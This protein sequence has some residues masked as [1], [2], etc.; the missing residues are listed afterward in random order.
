MK[1][2]FTVSIIIPSFNRKK[3][4]EQAIQSVLQ[5]AH[6][7]LHMLKCIVVDDGSNDGSYEQLSAYHDRGEIHLITHP[8]YENKGQS[9][10]INLGLRHASG[11]FI[12]ILDSDDYFA[13]QKITEQLDFLIKHPDIGMVYGKGVAVDA[14]GSFLY[15]TLPDDHIE[16]SDPNRILLD[17]Y[18]AIPGGAMIRKTLMDQVGYFNESYRAAQDHDMA[19]RIFETTKVAYLNNVAFYYRKHDDSISQKGLE[20]RWLAGFD[21]LKNAQMRW[22]YDPTIIRKRKAVLHYRLSKVRLSQ[23]RIFSAILNLILCSL[24]DPFR[25][26]KVA[27]GSAKHK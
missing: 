24:L 16:T 7:Q 3:Y 5:Q 2:T 10:S 25:S 18:I 22:K 1:S 12:C 26:I 9:A 27:F 15:N 6:P 13:P 8:N 20:T 14:T 23:K 19:L 4:I 17:C 11:D 21:I